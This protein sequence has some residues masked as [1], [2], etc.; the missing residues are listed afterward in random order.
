MNR[1][2][3]PICGSYGFWYN[4]DTLERANCETEEY[5]FVDGVRKEKVVRVTLR[6][7]SDAVP[8][9]N[10]TNLNAFIEEMAY[11][12]GFWTRRNLERKHAYRFYK[13]LWNAGYISAMR[14]VQSEQNHLSSNLE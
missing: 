4:P 1:S 5:V 6:E 10:G 11:Q 8:P 2:T 13:L 12:H 3:E 9:D 14:K 7:A